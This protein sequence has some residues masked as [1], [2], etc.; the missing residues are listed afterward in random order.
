MR[1]P[2]NRKALKAFEDLKDRYKSITVQDI[3]SNFK[4]LMSRSNILKF[5]PIVIANRLTGFGSVITCRLC[6]EARSCADCGWL[7]L[8]GH[9]CNSGVNHITKRNI[10][11]AESVWELYHA[12]Q[13][14]ADYMQLLLNNYYNKI[15]ASKTDAGPMKEVLEYGTN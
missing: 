12:L 7:I 9:G 13:D 15:D 2:V 5:K 11:N 3:E 8:T 10:E 6:T 4:Y 14:R 1:R